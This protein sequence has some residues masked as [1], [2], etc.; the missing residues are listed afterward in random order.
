MKITGCNDVEPVTVVGSGMLT[1][2]GGDPLKYEKDTGVGAFH[3]LITIPD[4]MVYME[5]VYRCFRSVPCFI[6]YSKETA[7]ACNLSASIR[8]FSVQV[9]LFSACR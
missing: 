2:I 1:G 5:R 8:I 9:S 4:I 7:L 6:L 3:Y